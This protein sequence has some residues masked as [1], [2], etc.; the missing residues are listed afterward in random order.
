MRIDP[1]RQAFSFELLLFAGG[2]EDDLPRKW[3]QS[4]AGTFSFDKSLDS[5]QFLF[6]LQRKQE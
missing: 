6:L 2:R 3:C 1:F 4:I 5:C